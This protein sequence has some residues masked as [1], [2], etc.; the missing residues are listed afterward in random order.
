M[1]RGVTIDE[2]FSLNKKPKR[3]NGS[4]P[5]KATAAAPP[6]TSEPAS[7]KENEMPTEDVDKDHEAAGSTKDIPRD[8]AA[9]APND[10]EDAHNDTADAPAPPAT[11][12]AA[13]CKK[14]NFDKAKWIKSLSAEERQL[15]ATEINYLHITWLVFL[16]KELTKP[17]FL[18]LKRFLKQQKATIFPANNQI[19]SWSHLTPL[20]NVKC[21]VMGQDPYHNFN[22]AHGLAFSVLEP[23]RPPPSLQNI[24]KTIAIDYPSFVNPAPTGTRTPGGGNLTCWAERGVLMLNACLTVEAHKANSHAKRGW[25]QFTEHVIRT[26]VDF[27]KHDGF[28][29]MAWGSPAQQRVL[30]LDRNLKEFLIL[31]T[32]HPLPLLALRGFF[33]LQV[34]LKCNQ[35][36]KEKNKEA[37]D[38]GV[39]AGNEVR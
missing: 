32:V 13:Y 38:W 16:H 12:Y 31:K 23:T 22:Q 8:D 5:A 7:G 33:S 27:H 3:A 4:K 21:L 39:V 36:L 24:Y 2:F 20:P 35:W 11:S 14:Y 30:K 37:I 18:Q 29:I 15:L 10:A 28:V 17:Y 25:E 34:F 19:Y 26:A 6:K 9:D 1:K